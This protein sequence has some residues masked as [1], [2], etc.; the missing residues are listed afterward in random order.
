MC[1]G[2]SSD[3]YFLVPSLSFIFHI[4][5]LSLHCSSV[6]HGL[7]FL[8]S[9]QFCQVYFQ[10]LVLPHQNCDTNLHSSLHIRHK[11]WLYWRW[12]LP[13][14]VGSFCIYTF[15]SVICYW[16]PYQVSVN[17]EGWGDWRSFTVDIPVYSC[18]A[19]PEAES[20]PQGLQW[21][22]SLSASLVFQLLLLLPVAWRPGWRSH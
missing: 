5:V 11:G 20:F 8:G 14:C 13:L 10:F 18:S 1:R 4:V 17:S 19:Q 7:N 15:F 6:D 12:H 21:V 22:V 16:W 2:T 9:L 3:S